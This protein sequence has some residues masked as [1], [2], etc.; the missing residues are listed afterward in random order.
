MSTETPLS[1]RDIELAAE[2]VYGRV[3]RTPVVHAAPLKEPI[4][5]VNLFIKLENL[6]ISGS[7]KARGAINKLAH[8][9]REEI[10][11]GLVTAS[12]GN[13]GLAVAYAGWLFN[14]P[15]TV[16]LPSNAP[17]IKETNLKAWGA[18]VKRV[19]QVWDEANV[20]ALQEASESGA[21]YIHPFDD[22]VVIAGQGTLALEVL[23]DL[24]Q[25]DAIVIAIGGGG[26]IA[27]AALAA[28]SIKPSIKVIGVEPT[29]APTLYES[30]KAGRLITLDRITTQANTLAPRRSS[31]LNLDL[32][33]KY[34]DEIVL[35]TDD[36][37][38][39]TAQWLWRELGIGTELS[40][41]A[42]VAALQHGK[43]ALPANANVCA[44]VC[45]AGTDGMRE[46]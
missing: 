27:G 2:Q 18:T 41:A 16:Y 44:V 11:R 40:S 43:I 32:I 10:A 36:E 21:T 24:Q 38:R 28:K 19:G 1:L 35:V 14:V 4:A 30:V 39:S 34:V 29:G 31:Q 6:Q 23:H 37:M 17:M 5:G 33:S 12:G 15:A 8:L 46:T 25:V 22:S 9:S 20:A 42:A 26:L 13:H 45:S 7:F 3:R